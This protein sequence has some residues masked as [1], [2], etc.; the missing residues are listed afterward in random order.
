MHNSYA[1]WHMDMVQKK[2]G[3]VQTDKMLDYM[4]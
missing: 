1:S 3:P 2:N 4:L